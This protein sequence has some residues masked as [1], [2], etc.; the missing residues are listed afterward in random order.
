[1]SVFSSG[2][3]GPPGF[4]SS[5][6]G[7]GFSR[8]TSAGMSPSKT[9]K[10]LFCRLECETSSPLQPAGTAVGHVGPSLAR[11]M[12]RTEKAASLL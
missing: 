10:A 8:S 12:P 6:H 3:A 9:C 2:A 11:P 5:G 4:L 7:Q 1:M